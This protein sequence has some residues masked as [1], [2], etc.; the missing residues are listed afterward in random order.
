M[1]AVDWACTSRLY[2][3]LWGELVSHLWSIKIVHETASE[4][5]AV[6]LKIISNE[7]SR[8]KR[9]FQAWWAWV[10][11]QFENHSLEG[12]V[13]ISNLTAL[14]DAETV[15]QERISGARWMNELAD[16]VLDEKVSC[17]WRHMIIMMKNK[18]FRGFIPAS[19]V[20]PKRFIPKQQ[21]PTLWIQGRA[22]FGEKVS[23]NGADNNRS[24]CRTKTAS[25]LSF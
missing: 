2:C 12:I 22:S 8:R 15:T 4:Y 18:N 23:S 6:I 5:R 14:R 21:L 9:S 11:W 16:S 1:V 20:H 17:H 10:A 7:P 24:S 3:Y 19:S 13:P 25:S